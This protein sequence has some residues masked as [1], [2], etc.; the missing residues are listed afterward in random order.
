MIIIFGLRVIFSTLGDG[1]FHC[2][3]CGVDRQYRRR[4]GRRFFTLFFIPVIPLNK[5]GEFVECSVCHSRYDVAVLQVPTTAQLTAMPAMV[6]RTAI[7]E[8]LRAGDVTHRDARE[9]ALAVVREAGDHGY[10]DAA[11][12]RDLVRPFEEV[13]TELS[14]ASSAL[15]PEARENFFAEVVRIALIDGPLTESE[16][17]T[18]LVAGADLHLTRVQVSGVIALVERE[19]AR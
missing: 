10:D 17:E 1:L 18:L 8:V 11:L 12:D 2:P 3:H 5:T 14:R 15:A 13:R 6:L 9:R 4:S 19:A 16:R 7:S